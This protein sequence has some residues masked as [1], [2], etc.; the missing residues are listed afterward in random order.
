MEFWEWRQFTWSLFSMFWRR[1]LL[2]RMPSSDTNRFHKVHHIELIRFSKNIPA[3]SHKITS[4]NSSTFKDVGSFNKRSKPPS[5]ASPTRTPSTKENVN[6]CLSGLGSV[7]IK[8]NLGK[9]FPQLHPVEQRASK[10][11]SWKRAE[12]LAK[13]EKNC[14]NLMLS[15]A[16]VVVAVDAIVPL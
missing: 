4:T 2:A 9:R 10:C 11:N 14:I 15:S 8:E 1:R 16:S 3:T 13:N 6:R 12:R 5:A 7:P